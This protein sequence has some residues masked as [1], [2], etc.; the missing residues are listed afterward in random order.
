MARWYPRRRRTLSRK[1]ENV[2]RRLTNR[3]MKVLAALL[4]AGGYWLWDSYIAA[5]AASQADSPDAPAASAAT[6]E[7]AAPGV[8]LPQSDIDALISAQRSNEMVT[9]TAPV[10]KLLPDDTN[11]SAHQRFLLAL[12]SGKRVLVAHNIDLA[13]RIDALDAGDIITVRGEFEWNDKGGVIHWTHHDPAGRHQGG[14]IEHNGR[15]YE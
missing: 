2:K 9:V 7:S 6:V 15:K 5:P 14:W 10:A 8:P 12:P 11:G 1:P 4:I 3:L 13:P